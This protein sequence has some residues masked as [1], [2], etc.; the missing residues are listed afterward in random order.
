MAQWQLVKNLSSIFP[1]EELGGGSVMDGAESEN[2]RH[3][4]VPY[5]GSGGEEGGGGVSPPR[6][7][8]S[9]GI[10]SFVLLFSSP[11][12]CNMNNSLPL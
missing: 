2:S 5:S 12:S 3:E 9:Q 4:Q 10:I 6:E 7:Q 1:S 11:V 8:Q